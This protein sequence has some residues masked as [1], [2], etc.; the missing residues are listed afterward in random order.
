MPTLVY[1]KR[2][3]PN[4]F[5]FGAQDTP[6]TIG[7]NTSCVIVVDSSGVSRQHA[8]IV[9]KDD[10]KTWRLRDLGSVN[11]CFVNGERVQESA[12]ADK[13]V[14]SCGEFLMEFRRGPGSGRVH[15]DLHAEQLSGARTVLPHIATT[16]SQEF[17]VE[18]PEDARSAT[19]DHA[20]VQFRPDSEVAPLLR[21]IHELEAQN[22]TLEEELQLLRKALSTLR[23]RLSS[24]S[25]EVELPVETPRSSKET[26]RLEMPVRE[27]FAGVRDHVPESV[28]SA[29]NTMMDLDRRRNDVLERL[30]GTIAQLQDPDV[31][32]RQNNP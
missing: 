19:G 16:S 5:V 29:L 26:L 3:R 24:G 10:G 27:A 14:L 6:I 23:G 13:D 15:M 2:G 1:R 4:A 8:E 28:A 9:T 12:L 17:S 21:R 22:E 31:A 32:S 11:G 7:R 25:V 18:E 30:L 20:T